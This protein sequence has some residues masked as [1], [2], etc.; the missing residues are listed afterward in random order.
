MAQNWAETR[1]KKLI[2]RGLDAVLLPLAA[3]ELMRRFARRP[4]LAPRRIL[5]FEFWQLGDAVMAE[6]FLRQLRQ[7]YPRAEVSLLCKRAT[8]LLLAPSRLVDRFIIA[9]IP[10]TAF[11]RKYSP[12]RFRETGFWKLVRQLRAERFDLVV[13][14]RMDVR[15]NLLA[16]LIRAHRRLGFDVPGGRFLLTDRV[17]APASHSHKVEDWLALLGGERDW[18]HDRA[19]SAAA[20]QLAVT[21]RN[22]ARARRALRRAGWDGRSLLLGVHPSARLAARRWPLDR[23]RELT[24]EL[25]GRQGLQIVV[26][27]DPD[28]Y[29]A[30]LGRIPGVVTTR[31]SLTDLSAQLQCCDLFIGND[32]GPAHIAAAV[33]V[34]TLTIFGPQLAAWYRPYGDGHRVV[35]L[36]EVACRPC[37]DR[38]TQPANFCL[39]GLSVQRVLS[40][41]EAMLDNCA[42]ASATLSGTSVD[43]L[44]DSR[45]IPA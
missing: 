6:P 45:E 32:S 18:G 9:D 43:L 1:R 38:C 21:A 33:G 25:V 29:G 14:A 23:F 17:A 4:P 36:E 28:G 2:L 16:W 41:V 40:E 12:E 13:D 27:Q 44:S 5:V 11:E 15:A 24:R 19:S 26:F 34:P 8:E 35:Q 7:R 22:A 3:G 10:W 42:A 39:T 30:E 31:P 20:P 37:F